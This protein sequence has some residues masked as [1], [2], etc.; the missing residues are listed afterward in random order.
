MPQYLI[1]VLSC[2]GIIVVSGTLFLIFTTKWTK[3]LDDMRAEALQDQLN[4]KTEE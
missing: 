2:I 4:H 3:E 1:C